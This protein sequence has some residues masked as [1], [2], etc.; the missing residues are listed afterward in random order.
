[1]EQ[2]IFQNEQGS[3]EQFRMLGIV[4]VIYIIYTVFESFYT[5][6]AHIPNQEIFH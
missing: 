1:M 5:C 6:T 3:L 4:H 2:K